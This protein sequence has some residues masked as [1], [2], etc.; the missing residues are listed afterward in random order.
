MDPKLILEKNGQPSPKPWFMK[1]HDMACWGDKI[2]LTEETEVPPCS[3][4]K[5]MRPSEP[6]P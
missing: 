1:G 2:R 6:Q 4:S 3:E 5:L